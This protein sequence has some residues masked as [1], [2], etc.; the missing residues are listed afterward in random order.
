[1]KIPNILRATELE[2]TIDTCVSDLMS[3]VSQ[4]T[5]D[6]FNV[7]L[8]LLQAELAEAHFETEEIMKLKTMFT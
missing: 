7:A 5:Y 3:I 6:A 2:S 8:Q 1:M 4:P